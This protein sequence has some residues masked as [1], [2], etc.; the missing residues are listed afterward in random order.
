MKSFIEGLGPIG[1][2]GPERGD[3]EE[4]GLVQSIQIPSNLESRSKFIENNQQTIISE[5]T[6]EYERRGF[7]IQSIELSEIE[8]DDADK[9][10]TF[11]TNVIKGQGV[12]PSS[13][14][15]LAEVGS[16]YVLYKYKLVVSLKKDNGEIVQE[17]VY[18]E[19][20]I[21]ETRGSIDVGWLIK[22]NGEGDG[23]DGMKIIYNF[24]QG[25][26]SRTWYSE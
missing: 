24:N 22:L 12:N 13:P 18:V 4:T 23:R 26:N 14:I 21:Q 6:T 5:L 17:E 16:G 19:R 8:V 1:G 3:N 15:G 11:S 7:K 20:V 2:T 9:G 25:K 10:C